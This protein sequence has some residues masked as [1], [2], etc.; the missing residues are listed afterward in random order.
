MVNSNRMRRDHK[1]PKS[2]TLL[3]FFVLIIAMIN[4]I[5]IVQV[6]K[7]W[8][9]LT[10]VLSHAPIYQLLSG[11]AWFLCGSALFWSIWRGRSDAPLFIT[12]GGGFYSIY[13]WI[14]RFAL[15]ATPF[16]SNWLFILIINGLILIVIIWSL[17]RRNTKTFFGEAYD[18]GSQDQ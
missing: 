18:T 3:A 1:R 8:Q 13:Y 16:D 5:R 6:I 10:I 9:F 15:S 14:D 11:I 2:V 4:L 12:L 17:T 7:Q